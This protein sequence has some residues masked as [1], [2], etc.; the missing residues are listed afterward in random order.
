M[1]LLLSVVVDIVYG[2]FSVF[3]KSIYSTIRSN[4]TFK[5]NQVTTIL[6]TRI[7]KFKNK[8]EAHMQ[9]CINILPCY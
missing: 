8:P 1:I 7:L 5:S 6:N 4:P 3:L 2:L 9:K